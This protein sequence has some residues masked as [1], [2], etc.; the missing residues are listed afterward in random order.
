M[1]SMKSILG[2]AL[3]TIIALAF[4]AAW[5]LA[6]RDGAGLLDQQGLFLVALPYNLFELRVFGASN[7]SPDAPGEVIAAAA[8]EAAVAYVVGAVVE[9]ALRALRRGVRRFRSPA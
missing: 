3:A 2:S 1:P 9:A 6:H 8:A 5:L 4:A 7:F